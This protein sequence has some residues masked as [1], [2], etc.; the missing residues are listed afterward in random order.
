MG[1]MLGRG[2]IFRL[3]AAEVASQDTTIA[4]STP[5]AERAINSRAPQSLAPFFLATV[6]LR[7]K[8]FKLLKLTL[9]FILRTQAS[10]PLFRVLLR[11]PFK[12]SYFF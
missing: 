6:I 3:Q 4:D 5:H 10:L 9:L 2:L 1:F 8:C 7:L 12:S 11:L